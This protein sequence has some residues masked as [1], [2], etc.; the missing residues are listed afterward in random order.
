MRYRT[1]IRLLWI[2]VLRRFCDFPSRT[3]GRELP[4]RL[5]RWGLCSWLA[6]STPTS[7]EGPMLRLISVMGRAAGGS[8]PAAMPALTA[9]PGKV[10]AR[11]DRSPMVLPRPPGCVDSIVARDDCAAAAADPS[12]FSPGCAAA[13]WMPW[14]SMAVII[15]EVISCAELAP[16][17]GAGAGPKETMGTAG[18]SLSWSRLAE[19]PVAMSF[20]TT[21][22]LALS[23]P[24]SPGLGF[25]PGT[26]GTWLHPT[27]RLSVTAVTP[28]NGD[29]WDV[30]I[31]SAAEPSVLTLKVTCR[32]HISEAKM[33]APVPQMCSSKCSPATTLGGWVVTTNLL[34][35]IL[36]PVKPAAA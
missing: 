19:P 11:A 15:A 9:G 5:P 20:T 23:A 22:I 14:S 18:A 1:A 16:G 21:P 24:L 12:P 25:I 29:T 34:S 28:N 35:S 32:R 4:W 2:G 36:L 6:A 17:A 26:S 27:T 3:P 7:P 30:L 33:R 31:P 13:P 8:A 10:P